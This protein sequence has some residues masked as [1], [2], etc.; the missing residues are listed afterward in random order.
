MTIFQAGRS[1]SRFSARLGQGEAARDGI[2]KGVQ[3]EGLQR[4][5]E[6]ESAE[7]AGEL[8]AVVAEIH[9]LMEAVDVAEILGRDAERVFEQ[10]LVAQQHATG[11]EGLEQPFVRI[12]RERIDELN[13][14]KRPAALVA[15]H[16]SS[17][18]RA[19]GV[20]P[21]PL[22]AAEGGELRQRIDGAGVGGAGVGNDA[23]GAAALCAVGGDFP[24]Q[25]VKRQPE[26]LVRGDFTDLCGREAENTERAV[27]R[28]MRLIGIVNDGIGDLIAETSVARGGERGEVGDGAT[29]DKQ[30][31]GGLRQTAELAQ[32]IHGDQLDLSRART[33]EPVAGENIEAARKRISHDGHKVA[34]TGHEREE[35]R[36]IAVQH[37]SEDDLVELAHQGA[38]IAGLNGNGLAESRLEGGPAAHASGGLSGE[39]GKVLDEGVDDLVAERAHFFAL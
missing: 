25:R 17:A 3:A 30:A 2:A 35:A 14:L 16:R 19:I 15:E 38:G 5:P 22:A 21:E 23:E 37:G 39:G 4:H 6:F 13:T 20:E 11:L 31:A 12:E 26:I 9:F 36:V 28:H 24:F 33:G 18:I 10:P 7:A 27:D 32:P 29:A 8:D 34:G 1:R